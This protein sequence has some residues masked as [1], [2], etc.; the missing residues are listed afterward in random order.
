LSAEPGG[1]VNGVGGVAVTV[2]PWDDDDVARLRDEQQAEIA[3]RYDGQGDIE[4][5]LPA[6]EMLATV[7]LTVGGDVVGCGAL[8]D[9]TKYGD[10]F[11]ELKRMYVRPQWRRRGL[12]RQVVAALEAIA[13]ENG[14]RRLIMETGV[15]QHEAVGL[16]RSSGYRRIANFGPY[17]DVPT[18]IC[19]GRWLVP[20]AGMRVLVVNGTVG[21]GKTAVADAAAD[22]LREREVPH[23]WLD[24]DVFRRV[25]P[26]PDGDPFAQQMVFEQLAVI[27]PILRARG[28]RHVVLAEVVEDAADRERYEAAFDGADVAIVRVTASEATRLARVAARETDEHWRYWHLA[29]TVELEAILAAAG[30]DDAVVDNETRPLREVAAE[31][32]AAAGW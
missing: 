2:V 3:T 22:L 26:R 28:Y 1:A 5:V 13:V 7:A 18:S 11:G 12:S 25:W 27:A 32:L 15:R 20:D 4:A 14:M 23:A 29:R 30:V 21:A 16:Y 8:R 17:T 31:V 24:V 6:E 10:G 9:G 19:Y